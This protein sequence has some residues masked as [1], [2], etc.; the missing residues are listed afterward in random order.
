MKGLYIFLLIVGL[1][2]LVAI[3]LILVIYKTIIQDIYTLADTNPEILLEKNLLSPTKKKVVFIGDS[4]TRAN[5]SKS[6]IEKV[7]EKLGGEKYQYINAGIN[8]E[9]SYHVLTRLESIQRLQPDYVIILIGTNDVNWEFYTRHHKRLW[10]RLHLPEQPTKQSYEENLT[11]IVKELKEKAATA[12]IAL[13][14]LPIL[15]EDETHPAFQEA[16]TYSKIIAKVAKQEGVAYLPVN[17][18]MIAYLRQYPSK[19]KFDYSIRLVERA[20]YQRYV[21]KQDLDEIS[22]KFGFSLLTDQIH[23]NSKGAE[24]VA[25]LVCDFLREK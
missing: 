2:L 1:I 16:I 10:K 8:S 24:I 6:F 22:K 11:R 25:N 17:E 4:L 21:R 19:S 20:I 3:L 12:K 15:G 7:E 18:E 9:L 14:S 5:V 13:C 23:L